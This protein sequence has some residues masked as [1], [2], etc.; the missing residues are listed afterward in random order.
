MPRNKHSPRCHFALSFVLDPE[1][2]KMNKA[3]GD[4]E[5]NREIDPGMVTSKSRADARREDCSRNCGR[6]G[7]GVYSD[8]GLEVGGGKPRRLPG[9]VTCELLR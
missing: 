3:P 1:N 4:S 8:R 7:R 2:M 9:E 5:P 6:Q